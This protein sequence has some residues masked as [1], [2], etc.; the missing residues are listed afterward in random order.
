MSTTVIAR[1]ITADNR[2][3]YVHSD[4]DLTSAFGFYFK[5]ATVKKDVALSLLIADEAQLFNADEIGTLIRAAKDLAKKGS[6]L[7]GELRALAAKRL[8]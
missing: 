3:I 6:V 4:G 5:G 1:R 2:T 8:A 7:P